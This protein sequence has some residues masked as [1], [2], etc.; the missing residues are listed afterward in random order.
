MDFFQSPFLINLKASSV[1]GWHR[2]VWM[3][4]Q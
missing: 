4:N 2:S 1:K 3:R